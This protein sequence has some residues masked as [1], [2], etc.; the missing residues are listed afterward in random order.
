M[1]LFLTSE[2]SNAS[3]HA[4]KPPFLTI[5]Q[6]LVRDVLVASI[7]IPSGE[8]AKIAKQLTAVFAKRIYS[9][10]PAFLARLGSQLS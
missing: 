9:M 8:F 4:M 3:Y 6:R 5:K 10:R 7:L 1:V 2:L